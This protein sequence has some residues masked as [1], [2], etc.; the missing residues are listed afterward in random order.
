MSK[1]FSSK[2]ENKISIS[3]ITSI[4][5]SLALFM[6]QFYL[7]ASGTIQLG[8]TI[9][10]LLFFILV[11]NDKK[12]IINNID[13]NIYIFIFLANVINLLYHFVYNDYSFI[14]TN[15]YLMYA[16]IIVYIARK[17]VDY[18]AICYKFIV[19]TTKAIIF[20]QFFIYIIKKGRYYY[21]PS[22]YMGT[23]NDPNQFGYY[24][25]T[26]FFLLYLFSTM[27]EKKVNVVWFAITFYLIYKSDSASMLI[28]YIIFIF[29]Y[30]VNKIEN[31]Y[32]INK[33]FICLIIMAVL[34]F[35]SLES[36]KHYILND[37]LSAKLNGV[38][39]VSDL[40]YKYLNDRAMLQILK[41]PYGFFYG[42]GEGMFLRYASK[43]ELHST[44]IGLFY[45]Y[46]L[47]PFLFFIK[48]IKLNLKD[49]NDKV[50][51]VYLAII[52]IAFTL[53]NHRQPTFWI[54]FVLA[55]SNS[56]KKNKN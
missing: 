41:N 19:K 18:D 23:F 12:I 22:R 16:F 54:I 33:W 48:W 3:A 34:L 31:K 36:K 21:F 35:L 27:I 17:L 14:L 15:F 7:R 10:L 13:I 43:L 30:V 44:I 52:F 2:S 40:I 24:I 32:H 6:K 45:Y 50:L 5:F 39:S 8:D 53:I 46:G 55:S 49:I 4:I 42:T 51:C 38:N 56:L 26:S 47:V 37:R 11:L 20:F 28:G 25:I 9:F 29:F 1:L